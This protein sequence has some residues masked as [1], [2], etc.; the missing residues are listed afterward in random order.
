M[1]VP[2]CKCSVPLG[3]ILSLRQT[4]ENVG[5]SEQ[6]FT[7]RTLAHPLQLRQSLPVCSGGDRTFLGWGV[8]TET[9]IW[10]MYCLC[11]CLPCR[12]R[13][14]EPAAVLINMNLSWHICIKLNYM[15]WQFY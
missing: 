14:E 6:L 10:S 1:K 13:R 11:D 5:E 7:V 15:E 2:L 4:E 3:G 9:L 8:G 12:K